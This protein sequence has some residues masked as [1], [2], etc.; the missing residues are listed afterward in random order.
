MIIGAGPGI[1]LSTARRFT[2]PGAA[3]A[4]VARSA[5]H[6]RNLAQTLQAEGTTVH[7]EAA[8]AS[9]PAAL[10]LALKLLI[11]RAGPVEVMCFSPLPDLD[12]IRPVLET[13]AEEFL[14]S[15]AL[16]VGGA[17]TAVREVVPGMLERGRGSL[18]F[19][20]GSGAVHPSPE[21]AASAVTTAAETA[22][23]DLL[24]RRLTPAGIRVAQVVISGPVG[25]G[26]RHGP[27]DVAQ[28]L[29]AAHGAPGPAA[30]VLAWRRESPR[31]G[32]GPEGAAQHP[33]RDA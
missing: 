15:L 10:Q 11:A 2:A 21:R 13:G 7:W 27:D 12:L 26:L 33:R 32:T 20:T 31:A 24:H 9:D 17:A 6:L 19:T 30:T 5:E 25:P 16:N 14:T 18:L 1:G 8:D 29:W 3:V 28:A 23:V 22:F 4:L